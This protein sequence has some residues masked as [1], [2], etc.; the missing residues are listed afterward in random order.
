MRAP[1]RLALLVLGGLA[2]LAAADEPPKFKPIDPETIAAHKSRGATY[3]G[4]II[5]PDHFGFEEGTEA[6]TKGL[7]TFQ[8]LQAHDGS[9]TDLPPVA[10]PFG[11]DLFSSQGGLTDAGLKELKKLKNLTAL[12]LTG[13]DLTDAGLQELK[14]CKSLTTLTLGGARLTDA[15]LRGLGELKALTALKITGDTV[16]DTGIEG[17]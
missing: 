8:F 3:G 16:T 1:F 11:L 7:P 6:A 17:V 9:L 4:F 12:D 5:N 2:G 13:A 10:V 14:A 15:S